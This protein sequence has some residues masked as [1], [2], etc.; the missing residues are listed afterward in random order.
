[1][2]RIVEI[3]AAHAPGTSDG[4]TIDGPAIPIPPELDGRAIHEAVPDLPHTPIE[5]GIGT[6]MDRFRALEAE[7][8]LD[9]RDLDE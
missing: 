5:D 7:G 4:I 3:I 8:R 6:T 1:M 2:R 9:T